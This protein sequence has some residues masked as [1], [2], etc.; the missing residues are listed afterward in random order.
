MHMCNN[1]VTKKKLRSSPTMGSSDIFGFIFIFYIHENVY[2]LN[3][4]TRYDNVYI[5]YKQ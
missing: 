2:K 3:R 5:L 4:M 1:F